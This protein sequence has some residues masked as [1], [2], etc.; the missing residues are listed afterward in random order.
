MTQVKEKAV[1]LI[2]SLPDKDVLF[3]IKTIEELSAAVYQEENELTRKRKAR[4]NLQ[5]FRG[6][7]KPDFDYEAE[8]N[9]WRDERYGYSY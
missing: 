1:A 2:E 9:Q 8:L 5:Q 3:I 6:R 4:D 7:L